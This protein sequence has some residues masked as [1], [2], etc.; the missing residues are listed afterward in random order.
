MPLEHNKLDY[1][2][3]QKIEKAHGG[4]R[5]KIQTEKNYSI[6]HNPEKKE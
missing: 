3:C 5:R 2:N 6:L 4:A 1:K